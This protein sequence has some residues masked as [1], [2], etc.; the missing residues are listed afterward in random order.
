MYPD[1][2]NLSI[3]EVYPLMNSRLLFI[4][5]ISHTHYPYTAG[6]SLSNL[7]LFYNLPHPTQYNH[8]ALSV[9][10]NHYHNKYQYKIHRLFLLWFIFWKFSV[11]QYVHNI[12]NIFCSGYFNS[13]AINPI[14]NFCNEILKTWPSQTVVDFAAVVYLMTKICYNAID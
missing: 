7:H 11:R 5:C 1:I 13:L 14:Y 2:S 10:L 8:L 9:V 4:L 3:F 6:L 12:R